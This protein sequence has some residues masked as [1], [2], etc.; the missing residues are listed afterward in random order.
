MRSVFVIME[1]PSQKEGG[2]EYGSGVSVSDSSNL[3][4]GSLYQSSYS[5]LEYKKRK[6]KGSPLC[7]A[8]I[9]VNHTSVRNNPRT[10]P[11]SILII[12]DVCVR[13]K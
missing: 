12:Q 6:E 3:Y 7:Q 2:E 10:H 9:R 5:Y 8:G 11:Y 1:T 13:C 4:S